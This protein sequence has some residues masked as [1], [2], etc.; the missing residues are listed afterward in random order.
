[1]SSKDEWQKYQ[2][3]L[4]KG[5]QAAAAEAFQRYLAARQQEGQKSS[6]PNLVNL[7]TADKTY[8]NAIPLADVPAEIAKNPEFFNLMQ[9]ISSEG[10]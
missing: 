8:S 9:R 2:E 5:D 7:S 10:K 6:T 4:R 1:M 3:A